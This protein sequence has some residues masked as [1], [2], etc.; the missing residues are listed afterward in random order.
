VGLGTA[1]QF[2]TQ[3][4]RVLQYWLSNSDQEVLSAIVALE[5]WHSGPKVNFH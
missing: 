1:Q 5:A 2:I 4:S 3:N